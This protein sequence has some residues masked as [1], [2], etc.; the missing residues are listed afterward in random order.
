MGQY[1][2]SAQTGSAPCESPE[3][4]ECKQL[5][6]QEKLNQ[7]FHRMKWLHAESAPRLAV[8]MDESQM[9]LSWTWNNFTGN[10]WIAVFDCYTEHYRRF[11]P[12]MQNTIKEIC[13]NQKIAMVVLSFWILFSSSAYARIL[14]DIWNLE[15]LQKHAK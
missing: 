14:M 6:D 1:L 15:R 2:K 12:P 5:R 13:K 8:R 3:D 4:A 9:G 11:A 10:A 7:Q